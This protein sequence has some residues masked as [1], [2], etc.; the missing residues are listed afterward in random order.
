M[1]L[2]II[3]TYRLFLFFRASS[4]VRTRIARL[5]AERD[6]QDTMANR[7]HV[8]VLKLG[9][10]KWNEWREN[11][12]RV[13]P[14]LVGAKL[15]ATDLKHTDFQGANLQEADLNDAELV[16]LHL[17]G[18]NLV[19]ADLRGAYLWE[20]NLEGSNLSGVYLGD[21]NFNHVNLREAN[22]AGSVLVNRHFFKGDVTGTNFSHCMMGR[23][24]IA[25]VDLSVSQGLEAVDHRSPSTIGLDTIYRSGGKIPESFLR[26]AGVPDAFIANMKSMVAAMSPIEFYSCFISYS[27]KDR[28]FAERLYADLQAKGVRCWFDREDLKI[29]DPFRQRLDGAIR[30]YDKL[31]VVLSATSVASSWVESEVEAAL[32]RERKAQGEVV[33]FPIRLD[34]AVMETGHAW[35]ADIR[36]KRHMGDF[37]DWRDHNSYQKAFQRLLRD[38]EGQKTAEGAPS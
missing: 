31:L 14:N 32:E 5:R 33:L 1:I 25:D 11:H 8:K 24:L 36:R 27:N 30:R 37:S 28:E 6:R 18:A 10:L 16:G 9:A 23:T 35:A 17:Q 21:T 38:L 34:E 7:E 22:L 4:V 15:V 19:E 12:P 29:G 20:V 3:M 2:R 26:G 13:K